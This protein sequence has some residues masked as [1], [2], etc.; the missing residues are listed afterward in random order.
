VRE[1]YFNFTL[2]PGGSAKLREQQDRDD[3]GGYSRYCGL[4]VTQFCD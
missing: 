2:N 1:G 4:P 3:Y